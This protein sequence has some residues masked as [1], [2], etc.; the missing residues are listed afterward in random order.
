MKRTVLLLLALTGCQSGLNLSGNAYECDFGANRDLRSQERICGEGW[1]CGITGRCQL[2]EPDIL[3]VDGSQL[4]FAPN[5]P[6]VYPIPGQLDA[7]YT[8]VAGSAADPQ[9]VLAARSNINSNGTVLLVSNGAPQT[10]TLP[11]LEV[12]D[13]AYSD[14]GLALV[15]VVRGP[16][17]GVRREVRLIP[18]GQSN[19]AAVGASAATPNI[20]LVDGFALRGATD[21]A[22]DAGFQLYVQRKAVFQRPPNAGEVELIPEPVLREFVVDA[23]TGVTLSALDARPVPLRQ[24]ERVGPGSDTLT[25]LALTEEGFFYRSRK[26]PTTFNDQW[27]SLMPADEQPIPMKDGR[28]FEVPPRLRAD[29]SQSIFT[30]AFAVQGS[31]DLAH[32]ALSVWRLE[33]GSQ[34]AS[35]RRVWGDCTPCGPNA[36]II[37]AAPV[38]QNGDISVDLLCDGREGGVR[39]TRFVRVVGSAGTDVRDAC[40]AASIAPSFEASEVAPTNRTVTGLDGGTMQVPRYAVSDFLGSSLVLGGKHGQLWRGSSFDAMRPFFLDRVPSDVSTLFGK[41]FALT[42]DYVSAHAPAGLRVLNP[43]AFSGT[44]E[45][46]LLPRSAPS[47]PT[48]QAAGWVVLSSSELARLTPQDAGFK[49]EFGSP[50]RDTASQ[51]AKEPYFVEGVEFLQAAGQPPGTLQKWFIISAFD[52]LYQSP[53]LPLSLNRGEL[54]PLLPVV[55]PQPG[56]V[57]R[58]FVMDRSKSPNRVSPAFGDENGPKPLAYGYAV[59][60]GSLYQVEVRGTTTTWSAQ[61]LE[62]G[63]GEPVEVFM[64]SDADTQGLGRVGFRDGHVLSLPAALPLVGDLT[65][66]TF[67]PGLQIDFTTKRAVD[68]A[69]IAEL[70]VLLTEEGVWRPETKPGVPT[71]QWQLQPLPDELRVIGDGGVQL[72][73]RERLRAAKLHVS[74][75]GSEEVLYLFTDFGFVYRLASAPVP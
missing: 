70:P 42:R 25:P 22:S 61:R 45:E 15:A 13:L 37:T 26:G 14:Q 6:R 66:G 48:T 59:A 54:T 47:D 75:E 28:G 50:L 17:G 30:V 1:A 51:P 46:T 74:R 36:S 27:V 12:G 56:S 35:L 16:L 7:P 52:S 71:Y 23:G 19:G 63:V 24:F 43:R 20:P 53:R 29:P 2:N 55:T 34:S 58:S 11:P 31:G 60:S 41:P 5:A 49:V 8:D 73:L 4:V 57:I 38:F 65:E 33:R 32:T 3:P 62:S 18:F 44:S 40:A 39:A 64:R 69:N 67:A 9:T 68:F 72:P 21:F 10:F